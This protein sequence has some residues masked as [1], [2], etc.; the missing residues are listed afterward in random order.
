MNDEFKVYEVEA[1]EARHKLI[2]E[3]FN[4]KNHNCPSLVKIVCQ[5]HRH[6]ESPH[7]FFIHLLPFQTQIF[8]IFIQDIRLIPLF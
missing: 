1:T 2:K 7:I 6:V 4:K 8:F 5:T 3:R